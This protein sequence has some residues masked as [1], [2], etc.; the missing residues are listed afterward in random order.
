MVGLH[1]FAERCSEASDGRSQR[2][3]RSGRPPAAAKLVGET[4]EMEPATLGNAVVLNR[5]AASAERMRASAKECSAPENLPCLYR[6]VNV[7]RMDVAHRV[8]TLLTLNR[9]EALTCDFT[10]VI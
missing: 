1:P 7:P 9:C 10:P 4:T 3:F 2:R 8:P 5:G 6:V